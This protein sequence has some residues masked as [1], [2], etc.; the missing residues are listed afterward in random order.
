MATHAHCIACFDALYSE[1]VRRKLLRD[2][3]S[4]KTLVREYTEAKK[5]WRP[6]LSL[7]DIDKSWAQYKVARTDKKL[8]AL[9]RLLH[10]ATG[11]HLS[12]QLGLLHSRRLE[13]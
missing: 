8:P 12:P 10:R 13:Q 3:E 11:E 5:K 7:E 2:E 1:L 4:N 9:E 6:A